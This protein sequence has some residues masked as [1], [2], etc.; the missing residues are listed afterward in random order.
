MLQSISTLITAVGVLLGVVTLR[1][2][3]RQRLRQFESFY[4]ARYWD[5]TDELSLKALK[6]V[7][8]SVEPDVN[9]HS[10]LRV[11]GHLISG[12]VD[13]SSPGVG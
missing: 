8:Q 4:I 11:G 6:G 5:L 1:A 12:R 2:S 9:G 3:Q 13:M 10:E 7:G